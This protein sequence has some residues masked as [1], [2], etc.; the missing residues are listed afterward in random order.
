MPTAATTGSAKTDPLEVVPHVDLQRYLGR[1]YEIATIPQHF[2]KGCVA[3]TADYSLLKNGDIR[4]VNTC[5]QGTLD[6]KIRSVRGRARV[7]FGLKSSTICSE[8]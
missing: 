1:W 2:Q 3:V 6:G 5:R 4:V 8:A 7:G